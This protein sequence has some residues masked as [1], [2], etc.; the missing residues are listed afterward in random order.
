MGANESKAY[1]TV[2]CKEKF[3][4]DANQEI[5]QI[6]WRDDASTSG[7][8]PLNTPRRKASDRAL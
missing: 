2:P 5:N 8:E 7:K 6:E 1:G 3:H 4:E